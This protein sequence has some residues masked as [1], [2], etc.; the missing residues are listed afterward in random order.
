MRPAVR[1]DVV[2]WLFADPVGVARRAGEESGSTAGPGK[3]V[4]H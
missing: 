1:L 3:V 2:I 4:F